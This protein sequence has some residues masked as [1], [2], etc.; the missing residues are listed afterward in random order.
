[1]C[2]GGLADCPFFLPGGDFLDIHYTLIRSAR[3]TL[4]L[5]IRP[6]GSVL[7]RA[8]RRLSER[9]IRDFVASRESWLRAKLRKYENRPAEPAL[10]EQELA[11]LKRQAREDLSR[12]AAHFAPLV[13]V[14]F[15]RIS[16]R[17]QK[18]RWGSC[19]RP[20]NLNFNC[21]LMLAP[22]EVRD[23]VVIHELCHLKHM[24][25]SPAFWAEVARVCPE[26]ARHRK[27]LKERGSAL[28]ARL[29]E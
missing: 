21:L 17:A 25:H 18:T 19:S 20:G 28:I 3:K 6:D 7:V 13:G 5:E 23:Y 26:Y 15:G 10:T 27:W 11:E 12:R 22:P 14:S 16:I 24:D 8:P 1:M 9:A 29:P 2:W 4:A